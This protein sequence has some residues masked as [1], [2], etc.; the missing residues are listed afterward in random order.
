MS[1]D[2]ESPS[3]RAEKYCLQSL[4]RKPRLRRDEASA[5]LMLM[6]GIERAPKTLA[7]YKSFHLGPPIEYIGRTPL[8]RRDELDAWV[9]TSIRRGEAA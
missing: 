2:E 5:Y 9:E 7:K 8:Y 1:K 6:H 3:G 4:L